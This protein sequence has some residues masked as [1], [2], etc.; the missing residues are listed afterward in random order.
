MHS[1]YYSVHG[2]ACSHW[3]RINQAHLHFNYSGTEF[4]AYTIPLNSIV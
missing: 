1:L 4:D 3:R 2:D